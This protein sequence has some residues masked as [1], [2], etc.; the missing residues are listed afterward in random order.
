[1]ISYIGYTPEKNASY[2]IQYQE[3][4]EFLFNKREDA[5]KE[6]KSIDLP[7][8]Y[9]LRHYLELSF[10][11]NIEYFKDYSGKNDYLTKLY[12][13]HKVSDLYTAFKIHFEKSFEALSLEIELKE[14]IK[15]YF[16]ELDKLVDILSK[17]DDNG[18]S[19][20]YSDDRNGI[21]NIDLNYKVNLIEEIAKPYKSC[22]D[23]L[24]YSID[25]HKDI[26][27]KN[28]LTLF[29]KIKNKLHIFLN[30]F[31][32]KISLVNNNQKKY[33]F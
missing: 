6:S 27:K 29:H 10:K 28:N 17:L 5:K 33:E 24:D 2:A 26:L 3:T 14:Q 13:T 19:F 4:F 18:I 25:V 22:K 32:Y 11:Y 15:N 16:I 9:L 21:E 8:F 1:M 7:L 31:I 12:N 30:R 23:L 20:R